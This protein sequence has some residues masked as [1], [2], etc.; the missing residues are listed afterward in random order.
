MQLFGSLS[1]DSSYH[2]HRIRREEKISAHPSRRL[3]WDSSCDLHTQS[4]FQFQS[5]SHDLIPS[6]SFFLSLSKVFYRFIMLRS[7]MT[8]GMG[9]KRKV[10]CF[11]TFFL[12]REKKR[13]VLIYILWNFFPTCSKHLQ[14]F[15]RC[16]A[17]AFLY[18][19]H[20]TVTSSFIV[21]E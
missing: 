3:Y 4:R 2:R 18:V 21:H 15:M 16:I 17:L 12:P 6:F 19:S 11:K 10:I 8:T 13:S 14:K 9:Q 1:V 20:T 7:Y 5:A